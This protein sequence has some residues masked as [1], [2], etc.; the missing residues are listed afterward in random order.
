MDLAVFATVLLAAV[1]HAG[2]NAIVKGAGDTL[3]TT[4]L[5]T[6]SAALLAAVGLPFLASPAPAS[7]PFIAASTL[8]QIGYF[9]LVAQA[10][11]VADMSLAYPLMRGTAPLLVAIASTTWIG[12]P[13]PLLAWLG[14]GVVC[15]GI[16]GM[17]AAARGD[18]NGTGIALALLNAG[19]IAGYTLVDGTGVR[20]SGAP[21]AYT[22][23][24]FL[25]TGLVLAGWALVAQRQVFLRY[26]QANWM[27]G[28]IGGA[29]AVTAYGLV[30]WAMTTAPIA[31]V[32][33]LRETSIL[34]GTAISALVLRESVGRARLIGVCVIAAGA[35]LLR[36]A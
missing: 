12:E 29:G 17:A 2:W 10:Y 18:A 30:L 33:A 36:L 20:R 5:V 13:L 19:F 34:F 3:L 21:A 15:T 24:I 22:M 28:L 25:L 1:L 8:F 6:A 11:R 14:V 4:V 31:I 7:W 27:R 35:V 23:W 16:L 9:V 26:A 32:A